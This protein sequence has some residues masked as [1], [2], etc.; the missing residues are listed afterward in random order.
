MAKT[1]LVVEDFDDVRDA[2]SIIIELLGYDVVLATDGHEAVAQ[3]KKHLPGLIFM[4]IAM[5]VFDGIAATREIRS[6]AEL[7]GVP[8]LAVT[9]HGQHYREEALAAGCTEVIDKPLV[10]EDIGKVIGR[11]FND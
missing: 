4:D 11:Y 9:A 5:P 8:I 1:I 10:F 6:I 2:M 7:A 3:A